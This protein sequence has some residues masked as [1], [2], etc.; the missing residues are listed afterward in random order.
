MATNSETTGHDVHDPIAEQ[1]AEHPSDAKYI[2]IAIILGVLTA[3]EIALYYFPPGGLE[4]PALLVLMAIKFVLVLLFFMHVKFDTPL[5]RRIFTA[6]FVL[7]VAIYLA[8]LA[9][10]GI[11]P[12]RR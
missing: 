10:F 2:Q 9:T 11:F 12:W 5:I 8:V 1:H 6:G 3:I 7:A 4:V